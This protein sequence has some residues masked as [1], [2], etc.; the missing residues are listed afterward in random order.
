[1]SAHTPWP[2]RVGSDG[3]VLGPDFQR[4]IPIGRVNL[5]KHDGKANARLIAA[6]PELLYALRRLV[7]DEDVDDTI[8]DALGLARAAIALA[9]GGGR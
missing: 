7:D 5:D 3:V 2:W 6:A 9:E 8:S 4:D 1:M